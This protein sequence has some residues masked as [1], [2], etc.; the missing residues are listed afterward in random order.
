MTPFSEFEARGSA[1]PAKF[2]KAALSRQSATA[3][4]LVDVVFWRMQAPVTFG[5]GAAP[6]SASR[7][8]YSAERKRAMDHSRM[9]KATKL[10]AKA[11]S[12]EYEAEA[13]AL[14]E[15]SCRVLTGAI[16]A[17][18]GENGSVG[19]FIGVLGGPGLGGDP[20]ITY[21]QLDGDLRPN[22]EGHIDETA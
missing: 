3:H 10:L 14:V 15:K 9:E 11:Q 7:M 22:G 19:R 20:V 18:R 16:A 21:G 8:T 12:T 13:I 1:V 2:F 17:A 4:R 6:G 5:P